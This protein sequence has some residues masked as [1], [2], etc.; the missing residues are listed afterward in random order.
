MVIQ[1]GGSPAV[2]L[3]YSAPPPGVTRFRPGRPQ[4]R[5]GENSQSW[6]PKPA[7]DRGPTLKLAAVLVPRRHAPLLLVWTADPGT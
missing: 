1:A 6:E 5:T 7:V 3:D 4:P 2:V